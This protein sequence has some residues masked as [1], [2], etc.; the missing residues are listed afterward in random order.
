MEKINLTFLSCGRSDFSIYFPLL[1]E[2]SESKIFN[3]RIVL[4]GSHLSKFFGNTREHILDEGFEIYEEIDAILSSD[5]EESIASSM[6]ITTMKFA[7]FFKKNQND[8]IIVLGDRYEMFAAAS[9]SVAFKTLDLIHLHG[10][11]TSLGS[12]DN[13]FRDCITRISKLHFVSTESHKQK[14]TNILGDDT[15]VYN[16]GAPALEGISSFKNLSRSNLESYL[17]KNFP[18]TFILST[19]HPET[20]ELSD[21]NKIVELMEY[22][23]KQYKYPIVFTLPNN[24]SENSVLRENILNWQRQYPNIYTFESLGVKGYYAATS[25]SKFLI[26]NSSSGI[27]ESASFG[28]FN[29]N[30]GNR[31]KGRTSSKNTLQVNSSNDLENAI[32]IIESK[33]EKFEGKNVYEQENTCKKIIVQIEKYVEKKR[34]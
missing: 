2:V 34:S 32:N 9:A 20:G 17:P 23:I 26:G 7:N 24:D 5:S 16:F 33:S 30:I 8:L 13:I 14:V 22:F 21:N 6:G 4:F 11:E 27:I 25:L 18:E 1:R 19:I 10:G 28:K 3:T 12:V 15:N 31:Q 29:I